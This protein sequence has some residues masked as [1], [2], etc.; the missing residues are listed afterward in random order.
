MRHQ[1]RNIQYNLQDMHQF[2]EYARKTNVEPL[3]WFP[4]QTA[5]FLLRTFFLSESFQKKEGFCPP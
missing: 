2:I 3:E 4:A 1:A 5:P